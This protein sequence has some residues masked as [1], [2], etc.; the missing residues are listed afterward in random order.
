MAMDS[1][2]IANEV[3]KIAEC[4]LVATINPGPATT[5]RTAATQRVQASRAAVILRLRAVRAATVT[6]G[7]VGPFH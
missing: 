4:S 6:S 2:A 7:W 5:Q 3:A 1:S